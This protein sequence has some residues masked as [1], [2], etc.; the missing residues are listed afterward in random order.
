VLG[1]VASPV[2]LPAHEGKEDQPPPIQEVIGDVGDVS[3]RISCERDGVQATFDSGVALLHDMTYEVADLEFSPS[4]GPEGVRHNAPPRTSGQN[5][6]CS[7]YALQA[8][9]DE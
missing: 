5:R 3:F 7:S 2:T 9:A 6:A 8:P 4:H 1:L